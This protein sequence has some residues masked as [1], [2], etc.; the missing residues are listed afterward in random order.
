MVPETTAAMVTMSDSR[1]E[2][3]GMS[4]GGRVRAGGKTKKYVGIFSPP[5]RGCSLTYKW[6]N[7][8]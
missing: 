6:E 2:N 1:T 8:A 5:P 7:W 3:T 4:R